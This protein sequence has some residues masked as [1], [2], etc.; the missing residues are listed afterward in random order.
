MRPAIKTNDKCK[1]IVIRS[2]DKSLRIN[3]DNR[4]PLLFRPI[5]SIRSSA[6]ATAIINC[7]QYV[8]IVNHV[9]VANEVAIA[10]IMVA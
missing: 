8:A 10:L 7:D 5:Y 2:N 6:L 9:A 3:Q 4:F 1:I